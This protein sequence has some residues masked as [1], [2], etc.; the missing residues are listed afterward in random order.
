MFI[1]LPAVC[2][3]VGS[4]PVYPV[5]TAESYERCKV[6]SQPYDVTTSR[7]TSFQACVIFHSRASCAGVVLPRISSTAWRHVCF[8]GAAWED[9]IITRRSFHEF[10]VR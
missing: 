2:S 9:S 4:V 1:W 7:F 8:P 10:H 6:H 3:P 5:P